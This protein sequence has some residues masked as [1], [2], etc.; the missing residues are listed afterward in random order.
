MRRDVLIGMLLIIVT[1]AV[2]GQVINYEFITYDD[3]KY[4]YDNPYI[5]SGLN[6][7]SISW[8]FTATY[9][10]N[11]HPITWLSHMIDVEIYG[12]NPGG[13]H[14]TNVIFHIVNSL[15]LFII[16]K[17]ATGG[18]W[19]SGFVA[20]LFAIHPLH[21]ESVAWIS[22][23][24]DVLSTLFWML[25]MWGYIAYVER[26]NV[27]R[28]IWV[29][30]FFIL[31]LMS[32]PMLVT[33]PFV[34]LFLDYWPLNRYQNWNVGTQSSHIEYPFIHL[35]YEK[36]PLFL[37]VAALC[38]VTFSVQKTSGAVASLEILPLNTRIANALSS[39][40]SYMVK[41]VWPCNLAVF[42]P[43]PKVFTVWQV[44]GTG[45]LLLSISLLSIRH[46]GKRPY[47][48]VGW[49][50]YVLTLIPVIGLV[51]VGR[52]SMADRYTYIPL[53]GLF[54]V[55]AWEG[56]SSLLK[57][58]SKKWSEENK[59]TAY[60]NLMLSMTSVSILIALSVV[61]WFQIQCWDNSIKL[62]KHALD[63]AGDSY[64]IH[65]NLGIAFFHQE[66]YE[67]AI[68]HF[69]KAL[70]INSNSQE[71]MNNL[72]LT[73]ARL[74]RLDEAM[75]HYSH[76]IRLDPKFSEP[77]N[78]MGNLL[79]LQGKLDKAVIHYLDAIEIDS[80][81]PDVHNNL[82]LAL[83]KQGKIDEAIF[84]F[85]KALEMKPEFLSANRNLNKI[86]TIKKKIDQAV[87]NMHQA[88]NSFMENPCLNN[89][90]EGLYKKKEELDIATWIIMTTSIRLKKNTS[91]QSSSLVILIV[92]TNNKKTYRL[93]LIS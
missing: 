59:Q 78:N 80:E 49:F 47:L 90:L 5:Q 38:I 86:L 1:A 25:T 44:A 50:W 16:L 61:T 83:I 32:K 56:Y 57:W 29:V 17:K 33:L 76:A 63:V 7:E 46:A 12:M 30:V 36:I 74:N 42:Y 58:C 66:K 39:Y 3:S 85:Q 79:A 87:D 84:H 43:H 9:A 34:L 35:F 92:M 75:N 77:H 52:Q 73:L 65:S 70:R 24:K 91:K 31:G 88:L 21:V 14:L 19:Q 68:D 23:R 45:L 62:Y 2:Y 69:K 26:P 53:I 13:H 20:A 71:A 18:F 89:K 8:S 4:V 48:F 55:I 22:E 93:F 40:V 72:G 6:S 82:G 11:W 27:Y 51:Q 67:N 28:Y 41:M 54:I 10:S 37:L 15:L 64:I 60:G 81:D